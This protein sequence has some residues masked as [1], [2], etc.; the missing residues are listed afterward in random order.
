[1]KDPFDDFINSLNFG[2]L[3][4]PTDDELK[5]IS[6]DEADFIKYIESVF[7][8]ICQNLNEKDRNTMILRAAAREVLYDF[9]AFDPEQDIANMSENDFLY[10]AECVVKKYKQKRKEYDK[11]LSE[12]HS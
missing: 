5:Q 2:A 8:G 11:W 10:L 6:F 9:S 4:M 7:W 12:N 1:M 3:E